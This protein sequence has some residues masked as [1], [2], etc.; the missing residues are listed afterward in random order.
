MFGWFGE[1]KEGN[2]D[3]CAEAMGAYLRLV[4]ENLVFAPAASDVSI[5]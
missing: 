3:A 2:K 5:K 1:K 4:L